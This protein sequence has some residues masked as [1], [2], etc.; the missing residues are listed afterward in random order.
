MSS[1]KI[2]LTARNILSKFRVFIVNQY[3]EKWT[4]MILFAG[5]WMLVTGDWLAAE[6]E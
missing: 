6:G 1:K 5:F 2:R 3:N 4:I